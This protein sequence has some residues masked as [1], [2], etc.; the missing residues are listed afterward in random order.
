MESFDTSFLAAKQK[1]KKQKRARNIILIC[2]AVVLAAAGTIVG[3]SLA[4]KDADGTSTLNYRA[5]AVS[6]GE[7]S[8]TIDGSGTLAAL[9]S[10]SVTTTA[11]S[12]VTAVNFAPGDAI[13]AGDV[14]MTMQS[15]DVEDQLSDLRD[16]LSDTRASLSTAKQLLTNLKVTAKKGGIVKDIQAQVGSIVDDMEYLCLIATDGK[17]LVSI[18]AVEGMEQYDAVTVMIG[19]DEQDGY[20]TKLENGTAM[21]V[22]TDNYYPVGTSATV[23]SADGATLG[24]GSI[25]VNEYVEVTA[26]SG[27]IATVAVKDNQKISKGATVFTLAEGAP[28]TAYTTLKN[29]EAELLTKIEDLEGLLTVKADTDCT[30]TA[31]SIKVGETVASGTSV[32]T[33]TGTGGFTIALSIDELDIASVKLGQSAT[34][35]LD[36]LEGEFN[37]K[38]SNISYAGSGSYVTS[39]TAT[40]TTDPIEGAYPGMSTSAQIITETSGESLIVPVSAVQYDGDTAYLY[41]ADEGTQ[42]G[43][44]LSESEIDLDKLTKLSVTTGMSDG[45]Y[46]VVTTEGLAAGDVIWSPQ[47]TS[48]AKYTEE[49]STTTNFSFSGQGGM[50]GGDQSGSFQPPSNMGG[51]NFQPPSGN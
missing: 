48:T 17:M 11:E 50:M 31:L 28:T 43:T 40:I 49:E 46:I 33:M 20:V 7:I 27:K 15:T 23:L 14:V 34:I 22:F 47:R 29:T 10:Q 1:K 24:T 8:T 26:P 21:I 25:T 5:S 2:A 45:S 51:G 44:T 39:Y 6:S 37:G 35:T 42:A 16:E 3:I 36:A 18:P 41:L 30:L 9:E 12:T 13:K 4:K 19:E 38:V 32:C